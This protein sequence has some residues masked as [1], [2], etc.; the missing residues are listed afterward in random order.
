M[1][2]QDDLDADEIAQLYSSA[3]VENYIVL[4]VGV[5]LLYE[6]V[7]TLD[8]E[9]RLFWKRRARGASALFFFIRYWTL[10]N[11][12]VLGLT[13]VFVKHSDSRWDGTAIAQFA[14]SALQYIPWG[15]LSALRVFALSGK[16]W[17]LSLVVLLLSLGPAA[18]N[19]AAFGYGLT[20][21]NIFPI[22]CNE[23]IFVTQQQNTIVML[24]LNI[25]AV[26]LGRVPDDSTAKQASY[27]TNIS[28]PVTS[29][30]ICRFL[31]D[32]QAANLASA[33]FGTQTLGSMQFDIGAFGAS[34][35]NE[36]LYG[37]GEG[38]SSS[39]ADGAEV[40]RVNPSRGPDE[41]LEGGA[42]P[43]RRM[44]SKGECGDGDKE[45]QT[46]MVDILDVPMPAPGS[47]GTQTRR[48]FESASGFV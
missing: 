8:Q 13:T 34:T 19:L 40:T 24:V 10:I 20:G 11:Y 39:S 23:E 4:A 45:S 27:I 14:F 46:V 17:L 42:I 2:S 48:S 22:G 35:K 28:A 16:H 12:D 7:I 44:D 21:E 33:E 29:I 37:E 38:G 41:E 47:T 32:L 18:V 5:L 3:I 36:S 25:L 15:V 43:L 6:Y 30:F 9:I 31:L 26:V 1:S